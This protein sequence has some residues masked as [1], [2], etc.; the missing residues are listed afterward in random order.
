MKKF[1][2]VLLALSVVFTY[3]FSAAGSVF[4]ADETK[5]PYD[6]ALDKVDAKAATVKADAEK[7]AVY[8]SAAIATAIEETKKEGY[9]KAQALYEQYIKDKGAAANETAFYSDLNTWLNSDFDTA[10]GGYVVKE[11]CKIKVDAAKALVSAIK[12]SDYVDANQKDVADYKVAVLN[13]LDAIEPVTDNKVKNLFATDVISK[14]VFNKTVSYA[15]AINIYLYGAET[16]FKPIY[17]ADSKATDVSN[18]YIPGFFGVLSK[19]TTVEQ[20]NENSEITQAYIENIIAN[21][22]FNAKAASDSF[23]LTKKV[24][25][26]D[27]VT[28]DENNEC[29]GVKV[30]NESKITAAEAAAI[31]NAMMAAINDTLEV[32]AVRVQWIADNGTKQDLDAQVPWYKDHGNFAQAMTK[33]LKAKD[34]FGDVTAYA[35]DM[36]AAVNF[37]GEKKY[38][39]AD[40]DEA[41]ADAKYEI[42]G[43]YWE[44]GFGKKESYFDKVM[45]IYDDVALAIKAA[46]EKWQPT[47][48]YSGANKTAEADKKYCADFYAKNIGSTVAPSSV[49]W[50]NK[51]NAIKADAQDALLEAKTIDE[52]NAIMADADTALAKLR[53]AENDNLKLAT[54]IDKYVDALA[55]YSEEQAKLAE[56]DTKD[57]Y[58]RA[59]YTAAEA[60]G[61]D[62]LKA[63]AK[64][65]ELANAYNEAKALFSGIKD[66]AALDAEAADV[67]AKIIALPTTS[68]RLENEDAYMA[69]YDAYMAYLDNY[70]AKPVD[71][72]NHQ[73]IENAMKNLKALQQTAVK[74]AIREMNADKVVTRAEYEAVKAMYDRY[75][76]Y[77]DQYG[78]NFED[79]PYA[80]ATALETAAKQLWNDEVNAVKK[81]IGKLTTSSS[82]A[83][84]MAAKEAYDAL[85]GSQQRAVKH[86]FGTAWV[87]KLELME[88][89]QIK[90]VESLKIVTS[91]KLYKGSKIRVKWTVKGEASAIDGYQVYKST[92]AHKNYKFMG[93]TKKS[94][95]DNKK[96]LKKGTRYFYKVRAFVEIDGQK[97]Y[98]D[99]SNKGNRIYKK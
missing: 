57:K 44:A 86:E 16:N 90:A 94:Y 61:K 36:K 99:W 77:Y 26:G 72:R 21:I 7:D 80:L 64:E 29:Y 74:D 2:T 14:P 13:A 45:P 97:H 88:T 47:I 67:Q 82:L 40:I 1:L 60:D 20:D 28:V 33:A 43:K 79:S 4:A 83:D 24:A 92:K 6:I 38:N 68:P 32:L 10:Y 3:S 5:T 23:Y 30:A 31:N 18:A 52:V 12:P 53:T 76:E 59:S 39:D 98:S 69:V 9:A 22:T 25:A 63:V 71:V 85:T 15:D 49:N 42:Y 41:L 75:F 84:V 93:K 51:Y 48:T 65:D 73:A 81:M 34:F 46:Y 62:L 37:A 50:Q 87:Y 58:L 66:K 19:C 55:E 17:N 78:E 27:A 96:G 70:G 95:M 35:A 89:A 56:V 8:D 91:T 54:A 11:D